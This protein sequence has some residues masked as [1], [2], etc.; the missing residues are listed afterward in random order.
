MAGLALGMGAPMVSPAPAPATE[1]SAQHQ[2]AASNGAD[3]T[4]TAPTVAALKQVA[5]YDKEI[6]ALGSTEEV[7]KKIA[8]GSIGQ[9]AKLLLMQR[10]L[11]NEAK[12]EALLVETAAQPSPNPNPNPNP[13]PG[14]NPDPA[15]RARTES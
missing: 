5:D 8:D 3:P 10:W 12:Y 7:A 1:N 6:Q 15:T 2:A 4:A 11:V 14:P 9:E 13:G